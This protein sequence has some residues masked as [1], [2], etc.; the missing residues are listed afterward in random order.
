MVGEEGEEAF[1]WNLDSKEIAWLEVTSMKRAH[2]IYEEI[3]VEG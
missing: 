2:H 1:L 3:T